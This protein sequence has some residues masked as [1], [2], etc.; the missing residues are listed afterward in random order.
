MP[1]E[2]LRSTRDGRSMPWPR[3][4]KRYR[5]RKCSPDLGINEGRRNN[6]RLSGDVQMRRLHPDKAR[7]R[8]P[9]L[10]D[11][12][13]D[14]PKRPPPRQARPA[15]RLIY[16]PTHSTQTTKA[17]SSALNIGLGVWFDLC[18]PYEAQQVRPVL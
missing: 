6:R 9:T 10:P 8:V 13:P 15:Q 4:V 3:V 1:N 5:R 18:W 16:D 14:V 12:D 7:R 2:A 17:P 11:P